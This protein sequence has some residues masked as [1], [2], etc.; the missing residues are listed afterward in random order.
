[1]K[2]AHVVTYVS[3][4]GAFGGPVAVAV[5]QATELARRGHNV[6]LIAGWDG[7]ARLEIEGVNVLLYPVKRLLPG[8]FSGLAAP[9]LYQHIR[10]NGNDYDVTHVHLAR[11]L[12]TLPVARLASRRPNMLITQTHG[13]VMP[14]Q[15]VKARLFD[16]LAMRDTLL[17]ADALLAL[18]VEETAG[19]TTITAGGSRVFPITNGVETSTALARPITAIPQVVFLARLHP[20]K[21]VMAF[22]EAAR[23]LL[24]DGVNATFHVV[25]PDEGDL[26]PLLGFIA[27]QGLSESLFYEGAIR[28]G[29]SGDR[30]IQADVYVLPSFGE[31]VPMTVLEA[32]AAGTPV[33]M[34]H[35]CGVAEEL[36]IRNAAVVTDGSPERLAI[37]ITSILGDE[38]IAERLRVNARLALSEVFSIKAV[39]DKLEKIYR[40]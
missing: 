3:T 22:A 25:G 10:A 35:D 12:I 1:L 19:L 13:M 4:D 37:A 40:L 21:R 36:R 2:I 20:R 8:G 33:V 26:R 18:T 32:M 27:A 7:K 34:T 15:R 24:A 38:S 14:D 39:V 30:L 11:D 5:G 16:A 31:V 29:Q 28:S 6:D 9:A 17:R 23:I